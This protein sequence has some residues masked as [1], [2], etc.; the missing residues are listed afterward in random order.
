MNRIRINTLLLLLCIFLPGVA[1]DVS[2]GWNK[3]KT[4][5]LTK[6]VFVYN[7]W[8]AY[9]ELSD[10]IPLNETL[11]MK[12]LDHIA[13]LKKMGVQVDYYLMDAFWFDVNDGYRT[14]LF[15]PFIITIKKLI[16]ITNT[17]TYETLKYEQVSYFYLFLNLF[18]GAGRLVLIELFNLFLGQRDLFI[19]RKLLVGLVLYQFKAVKITLVPLERNIKT[20]GGFSKH[21]KKS[22]FY[23]VLHSG[24]L[25]TVLNQV[26][27]IFRECIQIHV[28]PGIRELVII[29]KPFEFIDI[30]PI[31]IF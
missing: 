31:L 3:N 11:A 18:P 21:C 1:Q 6:P 22:T 28:S 10:N 19:T 5:R 27:L 9:D 7:N 26:L 13:R 16:H 20:F 4:A 2:D 8:S 12:E 17:L 23:N 14:V 30:N 24:R 25:L 15:I 29:Q